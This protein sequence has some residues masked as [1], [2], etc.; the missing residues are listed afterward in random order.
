MKNNYLTKNN[1][2]EMTILNLEK[3]LNIKIKKL[4]YNL[5]NI[6]KKFFEEAKRLL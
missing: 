1:I 4:D 6:N 3:F 2:T 5:T